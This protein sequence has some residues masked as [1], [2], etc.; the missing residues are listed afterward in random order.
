MTRLMLAVLFLGLP[1]V[2]HATP[3]TPEVDEAAVKAVLASYKSA[4]ERRDLAGTEALFAPDNTVAESGKLEGSYV[5][6]VA[7]HIGPELGHFT[8]FAFSDYTVR[9]ERV[10]DVAWATETYRYVIELKDRAEPIERQGLS[11]TVLQRV[12]GAWKIRSMHS[13][14]R[15]PKS[16]APNP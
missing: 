7:H 6:Y 8:R 3:P 14:S 13:S 10:G 9:V 5:D 2:A 12:D 15:V 1:L 4:L 11:T 16:P